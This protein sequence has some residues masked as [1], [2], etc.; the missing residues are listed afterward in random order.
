V[1]REQWRHAKMFLV[2]AIGLDAAEQER[3]V[4]QHYPA[5]VILQKELL[6]LLRC[7]TLATVRLPV[8]SPVGS[9]GEET[10]D[11]VPQHD[12]SPLFQRNDAPVFEPGDM[13]GRYRVIRSLGAGGMGEVYLAED[14]ELRTPIALKVL[15]DVWLESPEGR[16]HLRREARRAAELRGHPHIATLHDI[17]EVVDVRGRRVPVMVME[18]VEGAAA[19]AIVA[20]GPVRVARAVRWAIEIASAIEYAHDRGVLHCD[21]KPSNV[22][23]TRDDH[24]KVLDFGIA[25]TIFERGEGKGPVAGTPAYMAPEQ[26]VEGLFTEAG[27]LYSLGVT[28]YELVTARRPFEAPTSDELLLEVIGGVPPKASTFVPNL[29]ARLDEIL[30]RA[31]TKVPRQRYQSAGEF[32]RELSA[33]LESAAVKATAPVSPSA[34]LT[35]AGATV[36]SIVMITALGFVTYQA[37]DQGLGLP[38]EFQASSLSTWFLWGVRSLIAPTVFSAILLVAFLC[39]ASVF[40][41]V[42]S[43]YAAN[44]FVHR[45]TA[46]LHAASKRLSALPT[47][48]LAR[49]LL[50]VHVLILA[51]LVLVFSS[52]ITGF[53]NF[54]TAA[55]GPIDALRPSNLPMHELYGYFMTAELLVFCIAWYGL[56]RLR[57]RRRERDGLAFIVAGAAAIAVSLFLFTARFRILSHNEYERVVYDSETCYLV[58]ERASTALL[59]CPLTYPRNVVATLERVEKTGRIESIFSV[60]DPS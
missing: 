26:L 29:P 30:D 7:H 40:S 58:E 48:S 9:N 17:V 34:W 45:M 21:L 51:V 28:L 41:L 42:S 36:G 37:L 33:L 35:F 2:E 46:R 57:S 1:T 39:A 25:R 32:K 13:C 59:F 38:S 19:S 6:E 8:L 16:T 11:D 31:L 15:S 50:L 56:L 3:L 14:T 60:F 20:D 43:V 18:Y 22:Q 10:R 55:R 4:Q 24:A 54:M 52:L 27:D 23:I 12:T 53:M 49:V 44:S 47:H 5:D